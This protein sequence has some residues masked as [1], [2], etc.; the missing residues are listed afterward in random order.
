ML[1]FFV[2]TNEFIMYCRIIHESF[3]INRLKMRKKER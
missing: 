2:N 3:N 1:M